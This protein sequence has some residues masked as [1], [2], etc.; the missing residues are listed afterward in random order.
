LNTLNQYPGKFSFPLKS[1]GLFTQVNLYTTGEYV[2]KN[3]RDDTK[4]VYERHC[5]SVT[6][7]KYSR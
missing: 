3:A 2:V 7:I 4:I 1:V 5:E 6:S